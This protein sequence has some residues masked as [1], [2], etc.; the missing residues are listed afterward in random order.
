M[1]YSAPIRGQQAGQHQPYLVFLNVI[2]HPALTPAELTLQSIRT[3]DLFL[4]RLIL[5]LSYNY[6][7]KLVPESF[8]SRF[9]LAF[10]KVVGLAW[11]SLCVLLSA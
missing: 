10:S 3:L 4:N 7:L 1:R 5:K 6:K 9:Q 2:H 8:L 11:R